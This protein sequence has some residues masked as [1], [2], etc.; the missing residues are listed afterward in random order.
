[1]SDLEEVIARLR[2]HLPALDP[3]MT[4]RLAP[5]ATRSC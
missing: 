2:Q 4:I 5:T 3:G 1:M